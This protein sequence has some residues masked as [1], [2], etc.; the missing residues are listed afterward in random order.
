MPTYYAGYRAWKQLRAAAEKAAEK[1]KEK[2]GGAG[3]RP[4]E[5]HRRALEAGN[6]PVGALYGLLGV[7]EV[8]EAGERKGR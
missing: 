7:P 3:F 6:L 4:G 2:K 8:P 5:F 1:E